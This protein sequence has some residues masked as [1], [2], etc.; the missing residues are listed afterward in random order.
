ML[1]QD[2]RKSEILPRSKKENE[3]RFSSRIPKLKQASSQIQIREERS[4]SHPSRILLLS[5]L[6]QMR[7]IDENRNQIS[8]DKNPFQNCSNTLELSPVKSKQNS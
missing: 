2:R 6:N 8:F 5:K 3:R 7:T 1:E 4:P